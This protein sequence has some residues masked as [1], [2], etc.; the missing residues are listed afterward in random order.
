MAD[1]P[2]ENPTTEAPQDGTPPW[3]EDFD[4]AR[5]W[6][7]IQNLRLEKEALKTERDRLRD[8]A[9][10]ESDI[11]KRL[12]EAEKRAKTAE[13]A[14]IMERVYRAH[15]E[16]DSDDLRDFLTGDT[17]EEIMRKAETLARLSGKQ[18]EA[19]GADEK[20][21]E[22]ETPTDG[23]KPAEH[24]EEAPQE[25]APVTKPEPNLRPGHGG[26]ESPKF[27]PAAIARN[28]RANR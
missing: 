21:S 13:H 7:L 12:A 11:A 22:D 15:P 17:E 10:G 4:P 8:D 25:P 16:L 3:G 18:Q 14:L 5:A 6:K 27:D 1:L 2:N 19:A 23:E 26:K 28:S 9:R 20:P 24:G